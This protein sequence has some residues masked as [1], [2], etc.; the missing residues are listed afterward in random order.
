M[1]TTS[2]HLFFFK[3][4]I[5]S[6]YVV[7]QEGKGQYRIRWQCNLPF[8]KYMFLL[9]KFTSSWPVLACFSTTIFPVNDSVSLIA[10]LCSLEYVIGSI[11]RL[12]VCKAYYLKNN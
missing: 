5:T 9:Y 1:N 12:V 2:A 11:S 3:A 7:C 6:V 8:F 10:I 4:N